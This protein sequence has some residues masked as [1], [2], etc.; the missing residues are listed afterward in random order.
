[1]NALRT[2]IAALLW[3]AVALVVAVGVAGIAA[4]MSHA[5]GTPARAELTWDGDRQSEPAIDAATADLQA[6]S[7]RVDDLGATARDALV[8]VSAGDVDALQG[9]ITNGTLQLRAIDA[10]NTKLG[11]S[12]AAIPHA[13]SD[14]ALDVSGSTRQRYEE[15]RKTSSLTSTLEADW[16]AFTGR[17]LDAATMTQLLALHDTQTA[18]A[19]KEGTAGRYQEALK[20]LDTSDATIARARGLRD[21]LAKSSDVS[22]LTSWIDRNAAYDAALRDLYEALI[23][24]KGRVTATVRNAI[25]AE[26]AARAQLPPD[27]RPLV[28][29]MSDIEQGGLNQ[30]VI[31][32]EQAR[33]ALSAAL[34]TQEQI[35]AGPSEPPDATMAPPV[36]ASQSPG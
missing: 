3:L 5:P 16:A 8:Q 2:V 10:A 33:G 7:D 24:S 28:I 1:V 34:D 12:I 25:D 19:A 32:I 23:Q 20:A 27:T 21:S 4:T 36:D 9:S 31:S 15:L 17:A 26:K 30:A 35:K 13:G 6:L 29:I 11:G 14:W 18:A 22:T